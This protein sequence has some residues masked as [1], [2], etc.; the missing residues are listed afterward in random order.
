VARLCNFGAIFG[1]A[2]LVTAAA[3]A[4]TGWSQPLV[5]N[6][7]P[8]SATADGPEQ[9]NLA[10]YRLGSGDKVRVNVYGEETLSGEFFVA[11]NGKV[12][13]PL[14]GEVQAAGLTVRAFQDE[15]QQALSDGYLKDPKVSAEVLNYRPFYIM[16]EVSRPG[17]YPYTNGLTVLNAVATAGGF[18]YRANKGHVFIRHSSDA[19][20]HA[21]PL[22]STTLVEPG[23]TIRF[24]ERLF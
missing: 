22:T 21:A 3:F 15:V 14:V 7:R 8:A 2:L 16:G 12:S 4:S 1:A 13:L 6:D 18:T 5:V 19:Q 20:E 11:G 23:D 9:P 10:D 17:E 24:G